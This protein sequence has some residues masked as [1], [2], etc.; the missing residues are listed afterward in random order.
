MV[1]E[2][3]GFMRCGP[4]HVPC[5]ASVM[6]YIVF[7]LIPSPCIESC[8]T[9]K[10]FV[11]SKLITKPSFSFFFCCTRLFNFVQI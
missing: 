6:E 1:E 3:F 10:F 11:A 7:L 5:E 9:T 8:L 4:L 2:E